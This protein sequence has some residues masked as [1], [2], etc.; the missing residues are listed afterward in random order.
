MEIIVAFCKSFGIGKNNA[1]PWKIKEDLQHFRKITEHH[2]VIMG[3][4]TFFSLPFGSLKN[5]QNIV[6]TKNPKKYQNQEN[7]NFVQNITFDPHQKYFIIGGYQIYKL[8]LNHAIKLHI[9]YIEKEYDCDVN[10]PVFTHFKL[11]E[12]SDKYFCENENCFYRFLTFEKSEI[13]SQEYQYLH[14]VKEILEKGDIRM[15]RTGT[16]TKSLFAKQLRF[17]IMDQI[18]VLTTKY[19][20]TTSVI[21]ELL[22]FLHGYTDANLLKQQGIKIWD[23][24]TTREFLDQRG[25]T[26]Y[27]VGDL[28]PMYF[29]QIYHFN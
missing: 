2:T 5:R 1:L 26:H 24:H 9:T 11:I 13:P 16:G 27:K 12:Y 21:K 3:R 4:K 8:F 14:L 17:N 29:F 18:P 28:G 25:L 20:S 7:I 19:I 22:W 6:L 10:F 15:D 23:A